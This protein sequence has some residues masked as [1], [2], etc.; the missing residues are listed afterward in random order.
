M[1]KRRLTQEQWRELLAQQSN[2]GLAISAFCRRHGLCESTFYAWQK[3]LRLARG[4]NRMFVEVKKADDDGS[5]TST[6][7]DVLLPIGVTVRIREGF[8]A[9]VLRQIVEALS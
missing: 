5:R 2:S 4:Q 8:D 9:H 6:P 3:R 1:S 7:M